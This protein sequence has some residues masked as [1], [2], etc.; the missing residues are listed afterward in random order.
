MPKRSTTRT[1]VVP[2]YLVVTVDTADL[3]HADGDPD[4]NT[5][6][7]F[8]QSQWDGEGA[9]F[10]T[11]QGDDICGTVSVSACFGYEIRPLGDDQSTEAV[12]AALKAAGHR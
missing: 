7:E 9:E 6:P 1:Y 8:F 2:A 10:S 4:P 5:L 3:K 11:D 12:E